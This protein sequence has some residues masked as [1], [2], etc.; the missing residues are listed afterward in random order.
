MQQSAR[1]TP[2]LWL[3][4]TAS[5]QGQ[6]LC[7]VLP[8]HAAECRALTPGLWLCVTASGQGQN[9]CK[10]LPQHAAGCKAL[11]PGLWLCVT[12]SGQGQNLCKVLPQHTAECQAK[13]QASGFVQHVG[14][15]PVEGVAYRIQQSARLNARTLALC[16]M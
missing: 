6:N 10:V 15:E 13:C 3:C 16:N 8:Q 12:A 4:V 5:G 1:L 11:T 7:E 14:A 2:G 9:L